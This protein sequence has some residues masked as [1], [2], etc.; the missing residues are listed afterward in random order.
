MIHSPV[1]VA[2]P[3]ALELLERAPWG[4]YVLGADFR[5]T[6][7]NRSALDGAFR[8]VPGAVGRPFDEVIRVLWPEAVAQ[9]I[10]GRFRHTF[11][12]GEP[13]RSTDFVRMRNDVDAVEGYE[14]ELHQVDLPSGTTGVICYYYDS[15]LL[16]STEAALRQ[17]ELNVREALE[18]NIA[19]SEA[20]PD[21]VWIS[22]A[23]G[24]V[25][26]VNSRWT[27]YTGY[28]LERLHAEGWQA[29]NHPDDRPLLQTEWSA[30]QSGKRGLE[31]EFRYRRHDGMWRWFLGRTVPILDEAGEI[32]RW[33]GITTDIHDRK[34]M[35]EELRTKA[36]ALQEADEQKNRFLATLAHELR[37]PMAPIRYAAALLRPETSPPALARVRDIIER[38]SAQM[39]RLLD[40]L[41]DMSRI[42][43][44]VVEL[45][46]APTALGS[47]V[48]EAV[49]AATQEVAAR[50]HNL[51]TILPE[52]ELWVDG[53]AARLLQVTTNL[54]SNA[55][56]YTPMG[57]RIEVELSAV[58]SRAMLAVRDN[59][60]GLS[61]EMLPKL[62]QLFAQLHG[63]LD[64]SSSGL[65]IGL[66]VSR[67]LVE[68]HGGTM[69]ASSEGLGRGSE[70]LVSLPLLE[71]PTRG[72]EPST[73]TAAAHQARRI[74]IV[75]DNEDAARTLADLLGV[76][77]HDVHVALSGTSAIQ[78]A[79]FLIP[80]IVVLDIGL[81]DIDGAQV[82]R[83]LRAEPTTRHA[84]LIAVTG[85][86]QED[87]RKFTAT[88]GIDLHLV[89]PVDPDVL[90]SAIGAHPPA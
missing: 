65:G 70:F 90:M 10:V 44:D 25:D 83:R 75:D 55:I 12:T 49:E 66:A 31:V 47:L 4:I 26:Y 72:I 86:G 64:V 60:A 54:L 28:T 68:L 51:R 56:K 88:A 30:A 46:K 34:V 69:A 48:R 84:L 43:R 45:Q 23:D 41:L 42:T 59:G 40:D 8:N 35:E 14:W 87:D 82:A 3:L 62:F 1:P 50:S 38:Q 52:R 20:T 9:E 74:L 15:T 22:D 16:R 89:K 36:Q 11:S 57:G 39:A 5:V 67:R 78:L 27:D 19:I 53:D 77:G 18:R 80:D 13:F 63:G 6:Y 33:V 58:G 2:L 79:L 24:R 76:A 17:S 21:F 71:A 85:W 7:M 81:P 61:S 32:V 73:S 37:N 29:L